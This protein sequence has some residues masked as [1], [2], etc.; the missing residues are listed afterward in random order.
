MQNNAADKLSPFTKLTLNSF[1][2]LS[3]EY[4][5]LFFIY[6]KKDVQYAK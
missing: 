6:W 2:K 5:W 3:H 4:S 1:Y